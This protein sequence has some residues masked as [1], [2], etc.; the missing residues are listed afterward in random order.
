MNKAI[1]LT[2][3]FTA[4]LLT[5]IITLGTFAVTANAAELKSMDASKSAK[6]D[7]AKLYYIYLNLPDNDTDK[8]LARNE[9]RWNINGTGYGANVAHLDYLGGKQCKMKLQQ[10][11]DYY[12]I[13][14]DD[15]KKWLDVEHK[16]SEVGNVIHQWDDTL[17]ND[18]Q[19]FRFEPVPNKAD[20]YY[21]IAKITD[22]KNNNL[23]VGTENNA[24]KQESKIALTSKKTEWVV[25]ATDDVSDNFGEQQIPGGDSNKITPQENAPVFMLYPKDYISDVNVNNDAVV[26]G[27]CLQLYY[28]GTTPKIT[29]EWV[30]SRRAYRL[31]SYDINE[32]V[33]KNAYGSSVPY[34]AV[35]DV[36]GVNNPNKAVI[37][38]WN[39]S[40]DNHLS[41]LWRFIP[42]DSEANVYYIYNVGNKLYLSIEGYENKNDNNDVKLILSKKA[43]KWDL[44]F[45]NM[46]SLNSY[47]AEDVKN[48]TDKGYAINSGN[49]MSHLPDDMYL[50]EVN[51]PGT[52]DTG[53]TYMTDVAEQ[54][55][56]VC[57]QRL[58]P[59][60]Q[61]NSGVRAWDIR[62]NR[63]ESINE[64]SNPT[65]IHGENF[66]TC[67]NRDGSDMTLR[68]IMD[69]AKDFLKEHPY[70]TVVMTLKADSNGSDEII[71]DIVLKQYLN[72]KNYPIYKP[73][74]GGSEYSP[75][76]KD[77]RGKIVF[78]RRLDFS[79][80]YIKKAESKDLGFSVMDAFGM[81][82]SRWDDN[83]YSLNKNAVRVGKSNIYVQD[84]YGER[85]ADTKLLYFYSTISDATTNKYT[86][87]GNYLFNYSGA[88]DNINQP[89]IVNRSLME[90]SFLSQPA[91]SSAIQSIGF[92][93]ANYID[94]KLSE[95]IYMTNFVSQHT[96][97]YN[98]KGFCTICGQYQPAVYNKSTDVYTINN[99][100]QLFWFSSLVNGDHSY[101][102]FDKQNAGANAELAANID[103]ENKEWAPVNNY[104]GNFN[105]KGHSILN[106]NISKA[107][108]YTGLFGSVNDGSVSDITVYGDI[109]VKNSASHIGGV[110]GYI[111]FGSVK[112]V[113]SYVNINNDKYGSQIAHAGGIIGSVGNDKTDIEKCMYYG[114][115]H[116]NNSSDCIGGVIAYSN[117]G[118]RVKNCANSGTVTAT[119]SGAY[120][121]GILGYLNNTNPTIE[122]CYNYTKISDNGSGI[123]CG[124]I[125]GWARNF[126]KSNIANNYY[127][128]DTGNTPFGTDSKLGLSA[129]EK[130]ISEFKCGEVAFKLNNGVTDGTQSWYQNIDN[131]LT[132]DDYPVFNGGT[133]YYADFDNTYS[134]FERTPDEFDK[135][136]DGRFIIKTYSDLVKLSQVVR[137]DYKRY[138]DKNYILVNNIYADE[139]SSWA[140]GIG[141]VAE[142]KPFNGTFDGNGY[143]IGALN[144]SAGEYGGLFEFIGEKGIVKDLFVYDCDFKGSAKTGGG[145]AAVNDGVIDH[146]VSGIN[147][148]SGTIFI[149]N[150]KINASDLNSILNADVCGGVAGINNGKITGTRNCSI[151]KGNECGGISAINTG[152]IYGCANTGKT[153]L[154]TSTVAGGL[155]GKNS[156]KIESSYNCGNVLCK[157]NSAKGSIVGLNGVAG[158]D[159]VTV[160]NVFY[161]AQNSLN[162][163]GTDSQAKA[164]S[165]NIA[166]ERTV[167]MASASL[168]DKL[169]SVTDDSINF[170]CSDF[171]RGYPYIKGSF[172]KYSVKSVG[173]GITLSGNMHSSLNVSYTAYSTDDEQYKKF[174]SL[175]KDGK[176]LDFYKGTLSDNNGN[177]AFAEFWCDNNLKL[178]LPVSGKNVSLAVLDGDGGIKYIKPDSFENGKAVFTLSQPT[179]FA[180]VETSSSGGNNTGNT[181]IDNTTIKTGATV[182]FT[183]S[184]TAIIALLAFAVLKKRGR[185]EK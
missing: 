76:L 35:W 151:V 110:V 84:N 69:T 67:H 65:I 13:K 126:N 88:K 70:E 58:Y 122:N 26:Q 42:V 99:A 140:Q 66:Y 3:S 146:C 38:V 87:Q 127:N 156:G 21:I 60:E 135:D 24:Y 170:I 83:D 175:I 107:S 93:M 129:N 185:I 50:S 121:G 81:D 19:Y 90:D 22:Q 54:L 101:A 104:K 163:V 27:N 80:S 142:N 103:L 118:A 182:I 45:L 154:D 117:G 52:H 47:T 28:T 137:T 92:V 91:T 165:T 2:K 39:N 132:P 176:I 40:G 94:A 16:K 128:K 17:K 134:N 184:F 178:T 116:L 4:L 41:Q 111:N 10:K 78:I 9:F 106:L 108:D 105:G 143:S 124:A 97:T 119:Q 120:V 79:D 125:I 44:K 167:E 29:A 86:E 12:G 113:V 161:T 7:T 96:H 23:Y 55:S 34:D 164:D 147:A 162:A 20:T 72:N 33:P 102:D 30:S 149:K 179:D 155:V 36:D 169:N 153:G 183:I 174:E 77:V 75:K 1:R 57:C 31:R 136:D 139:N 148:V 82:A 32:N 5:A 157:I 14:C 130:T 89:R 56:I 15:F 166:Y 37:H 68:N 25:K 144:I 171:N 181:Q 109:T 51:M 59:D 150:L 123:H 133:V 114:N 18:N 64:N 8:P 172:L 131:G 53:A 100:G 138:G 98:E 168:A 6:F 11:G 71:G 48:K 95:R 62:I 152:E 145:I 43:F 160:K 180:L 159:G 85:D 49:W 63:K 141:S 158:T 173:N 46:N 61:L 177:S 73:Q 112:N 115:I 74:K